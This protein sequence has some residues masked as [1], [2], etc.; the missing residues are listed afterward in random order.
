MKKSKIKQSRSILVAV[1]ALLIGGGLLVGAAL[2]STGTINAFTA[3][4]VSPGSGPIIGGTTITITGT[5]FI[6]KVGW[7]QIAPGWSH[8]CAITYDDGQLYCWGSNYRGQLGDNTTVN[9][10]TPVLANN[11][12][13]SGKTVV[14]AT[15]G[16]SHTCALDTVGQVYCWGRNDN[17]QLGD[18][19]T[20]NKRVPT[21]IN[22]G[23]LAGKTITAIAAGNYHTCALDTVGQ[24]YCW[25]S[26]GD[27]QLGDSTTAEKHVPTLIN[28]GALSGKT[29]A[30]I[31]G[32]GDYTCAID[33]TG[34][35]YCWGRNSLGHLGDNTTVNKNIPTLING[36]ALSGKNVV[37]VAGSHDH[38]CAIDTTGQLYCWGNNNHGQLGDNT[39]VNKSVPTLINGGALA[40]KTIAAVTAGASSTNSGT[41]ALDTNNQ[42][43]CWG[44]NT[45][46]QIGDGTTADSSVPVLVNGGA[47]AGKTITTIMSNAGGA[48]ASD[49]VD[50]Y[51][52]GDNYTGE[53]G[54]GTTVASSVPVLVSTSGLSL[55]MAT[56]TVTVDGLGCANVTVVSSTEITCIVPAHVKGLTDV[57]V[58]INGATVTLQGAFEYVSPS[59][60]DDDDGDNGGGGGN[61]TPDTPPNTGVG[62]YISNNSELI[63]SLSVIFGVSVAAIIWLVA[64]KKLRFANI[65]NKR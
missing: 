55:S 27:G 48:C 37:A 58:F 44:S 23:A 1:A 4:N 16:N 34:Q 50:L 63:V 28:G 49:T 17:G 22:G 43:Y 9:K 29:V 36:G 46:G 8:T 39:T 32:G 20:V 40:G 19:T 14:A 31:S 51:C 45:Y 24:V 25:G 64:S 3:T 5:D 57:A 60:D 12:D 13:L 52:W 62:I 47:L 61:T 42:I 35:L 11:G 56:P 33:T 26:N 59:G 21:L 53:L 41:C 15:A 30:V 65:L 18:N 2:Q 54:N 38:T 6:Q 7:K 10:T